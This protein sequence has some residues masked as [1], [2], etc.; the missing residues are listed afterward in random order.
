MGAPHLAAFSGKL[1]LEL[2]IVTA[3]GSVGFGLAGA[4]LRTGPP[5]EGEVFPGSEETSWAVYSHSGKFYHRCARPSHAHCSL[6]F[7]PD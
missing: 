2:R 5:V 3:Q 7:V 1:Y 4:G 6:P